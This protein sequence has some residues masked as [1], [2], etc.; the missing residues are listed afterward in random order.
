MDNSR[1]DLIR[2][3]NIGAGNRERYMQELRDFGVSSSLANFLPLEESD[4]IRHH[5]GKVF[6]GR[7]TMMSGVLE[8]RF[9]FKD[10]ENMPDIIPSGDEDVFVVPW[11]ADIV[12]ILKWPVSVLNKSWKRLIQLE[13]DGLIVVDCNFTSKIVIQVVDDS[14]E[15]ELDFGVWGGHWS[16]Y[17]SKVVKQ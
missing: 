10:I 2:R 12:G 1:L 3:K 6:V 15:K 7:D 11:N 8:K 5:I 4:R 17:L 16:S 14:V 9:P 13:P